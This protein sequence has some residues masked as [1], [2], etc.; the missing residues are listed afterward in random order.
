MSKQPTPKH[1]RPRQ[2]K[3]LTKTIYSLKKRASKTVAKGSTM[4]RPQKELSVSQNRAIAGMVSGL[5]DEA[6][7][8]L[9]GVTRKTVSQWKNH[10]AIFRTA[11]NE[12]QAK[13]AKELT[14]AYSKN[15]KSLVNAAM[16]AVAM[17][18]K[19]EDAQTARWLL[20][21]IGFENFAKQNFNDMV[22]PDLPPTTLLSVIDEMAS[23]RVDEFLTEKGVSPID[24]LRLHPILKKRE[25]EALREKFDN[26]ES[27]S[28]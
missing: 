22:N 5:S 20:D 28:E 27:D 3:P 19:K 12:A 16:V 7:A 13:E 26:D 6:S 8:K 1:R 11:L 24:R 9:A 17:A 4:L 23:K 2:T 10:D 15:T 18:L 21:K 14:Q 25:N